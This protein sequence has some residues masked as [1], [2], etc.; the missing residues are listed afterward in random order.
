MRN[1]PY[2][3]VSL[4]K[5]TRTSKWLIAKE[6]IAKRRK[7]VE[8]VWAGLPGHRNMDQKYWTVSSFKCILWRWC[9]RCDVAFVYVLGGIQTAVQLGS[10]NTVCMLTDHAH[11]TTSVDYMVLIDLKTFL[12]SVFVLYLLHL[13]SQ[14]QDGRWWNRLVE[15][16][17]CFNGKHL[18][19]LFLFLL[20]LRK[21]A[22]IQL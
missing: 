18:L 15:H 22:R 8:L 19:L 7:K 12:T 6:N 17:M 11:K 10:V 9:C 14:L 5:A 13:S 3:E 2:P 20:I 16:L 4:K 1:L 21:F